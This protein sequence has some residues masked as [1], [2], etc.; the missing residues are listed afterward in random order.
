MLQSMYDDYKNKG[1]DPPIELVAS[2][3][4]KKGM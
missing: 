2:L 3:N 1:Q 4:K